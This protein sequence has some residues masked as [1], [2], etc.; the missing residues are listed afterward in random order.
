MA[1][2]RRL[3]AE[4]LLPY[5]VSLLRAH[6]RSP[7]NVCVG[8][9][10]GRDSVV[11]LH[12]IGQVRAEFSMSVSA[13]HVNHQ[14]SPNANRWADFCLALCE[15]IAI[16]LRI[17]QVI[18]ARDSGKGLE[19]SA[20]AARYSAYARDAADVILLAHHRDDQAE[21]VLLQALRGAGLKGISAM[22]TVKSLGA[23]KQIIRPLLDI[24][25]AILADY[26]AAN[27]LTWIHDESNDDVHYTRNYLRHDIFPR[28]AEHLPQSTAS[29]VRLGQHATEAQGLLDDLAQ[30]DS[31][32]VLCGDRI[33]ISQL[34]SLSPAR[35]KNFLRYVFKKGSVPVPNSV[36]MNEILQ[37]LRL[38]KADDQTE[39]KWS[40][41]RIRCF[42]DEIYFT[43]VSRGSHGAW[44]VPWL[45]EIQLR[46]PHGC[47]E[48][49]IKHAIG[50]G[51]AQASIA[52]RIL[53]LKSRVGGEK[54]R[55][56]ENRPR[57]SLKNLLQEKGMPPW[58]RETMP[59]LFCDETLIWVPDVGVDIQY[60][61]KSNE[62]SFVFS[63]QDETDKGTVP[64]GL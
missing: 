41:W 4:T 29:L 3:N 25:P 40:N 1:S 15:K 28:L 61:A 42:R 30:I 14:I 2:T 55:L 12:L 47:G 39:I 7:A 21:T 49:H 62:P 27:D 26:A 44:S 58:S 35:A 34:L 59:L 13:I 50:T 48:L 37:Q 9:S 57:R 18:V 17:E 24:A 46:L 51:V 45:G 11:L 16:P 52:G 20:R 31:E 64:E 5:V 56:A 63:W 10:G 43:H 60:A 23:D 54:I 53:F 38:R 36:Q 22:P 6:V 19:A 32:I 33:R 8:L